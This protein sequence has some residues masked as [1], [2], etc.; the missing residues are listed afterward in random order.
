MALDGLMPAEDKTTKYDYM[1]F[2]DFESF[3]AP[4]LQESLRA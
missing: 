2:D 4:L 3:M 1:A